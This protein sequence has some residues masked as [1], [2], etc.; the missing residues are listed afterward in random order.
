[1]S[2]QFKKYLALHVDDSKQ[3]NMADM[4]FSGLGKSET[5]CLNWRKKS[6]HEENNKWIELNFIKIKKTFTISDCM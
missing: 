1:V 6:Q 3:K 2:K 4:W 5:H